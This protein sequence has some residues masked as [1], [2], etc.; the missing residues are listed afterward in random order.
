MTARWPQLLRLFDP[1]A[2]RAA[3]GERLYLASLLLDV[4]PAGALRLYDY[5]GR[6]FAAAVGSLTAVFLVELAI[7]PLRLIGSRLWP[8]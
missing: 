4:S 2:R 3:M 5:K 1:F 8:P 6:T 7:V